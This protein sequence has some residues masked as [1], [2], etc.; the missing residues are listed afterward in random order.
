MTGMKLLGFSTA[1]AMKGSLKLELS[2][3]GGVGS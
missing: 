3:R 1:L 2:S